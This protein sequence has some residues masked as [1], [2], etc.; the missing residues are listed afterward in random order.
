M[1]A[2]PVPLR[3]RTAP[4]PD[5]PF[6]AHAIGAIAATAVHSPQEDFIARV[7][8]LSEQNFYAC[9]QCG[10]CTAGC[11]FSFS[12]QQVIRHLQLGQVDK[13]LALESVWSCPGCFTCTANC[14]KGVDPA[15]IMRALRSVSPD[16]HGLRRRAWL[17]ANNHRFAGTGSRFAPVSNWLMGA[18]GV[19]LV[20][21]Y[22]IGIHRARSLPP[23]AHRTFPEWFRA[24]S[25]IGDGHRG[26][27]LLFHDTF[28]DY[29]HPDT[30]IAATEL[31]ELAGFR[32]ELT[33]TVCCG[34]PMISKGFADQ[35]R[36]QA[37]TNVERLSEQAAGGLFV[38]GCEP[39]C[40][41][42]FRSEYPELLRGTDLREKGADHRPAVLLARRV[43][44]PARRARRARAPIR[45]ERPGPLPR[46]LPAEGLRHA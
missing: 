33:D 19:G 37:R 16:R 40:L 20:S 24:R 42:T 44:R 35:A 43:P 13:A 4:P 38:V 2:L 9:Y 32:V 3:R 18:S 22:A 23:Y 17:I 30:G 11:P 12:P 45:G 31:L 10:K 5:A 27:V 39:S 7:A 28:M 15:R 34:R 14:P 29:N 6:A 8:E 26:T 41:L 21:Q 1:R 25:P 46:P 36:G